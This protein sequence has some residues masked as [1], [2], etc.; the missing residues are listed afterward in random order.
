VFGDEHI[1]R[2]YQEHRTERSVKSSTRQRAALLS[3]AVDAKVVSALCNMGFGRQQASRALAKL[4]AT[5][6]GKDPESVL[7]AALTVLVPA[8]AVVTQFRAYVTRSERD[9][10]LVGRAGTAV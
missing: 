5:D 6:V 4:R 3:E 1:D 8:H 7:R 2:K 9:P 10:Q